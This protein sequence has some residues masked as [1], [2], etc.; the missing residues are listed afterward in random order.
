[1]LSMSIQSSINGTFTCPSF[2]S[3]NPSFK[4]LKTSIPMK[5]SVFSLHSSTI[6]ELRDRPIK[7]IQRLSASATTEAVT[8]ESSSEN[9]TP[10]TSQDSEPSEEA[11]KLEVVVKSVAKPRLVLKFIW[12]EKNIGL[13]LDQVIPG[14]GTIPLSPVPLLA[15]ERCMG[16]AEIHSRE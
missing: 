12:M 13:A 2:P 10:A 7:R 3:P 6:L 11:E 8:E 5:H 14:H 9:P 1:M 15:K 4:P 16:R